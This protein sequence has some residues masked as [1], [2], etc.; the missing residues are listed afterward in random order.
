M[1]LPEIYIINLESSVARRARI[2]QS[3][4]RNLS[5]QIFPAI[6][7]Q[8]IGETYS[9]GEHRFAKT[10]LLTHNE[11]ACKMSHLSLLHQVVT[12]GLSGAVILED[13]VLI[14]EGFDVALANLVEQV[15]PD[16][17]IVYLSCNSN[18]HANV[19]WP[20]LGNINLVFNHLHGLDRSPE[21]PLL[22]RLH[23]AWGS[24]AYLVSQTGAKK[25]IQYVSE[26]VSNEF[27]YPTGLGPIHRYRFPTEAIDLMLVSNLNRL[28][29]YL[30]LPFLASPNLD[31]SDS[32]IGVERGY[33]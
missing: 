10:D 13:D 8:S 2:I 3:M 31:P 33:S 21:N 30:T 17:D 4:P 29:A 16:F 24:P 23:R 28:N 27:D 1:A 32:A 20:G 25:I 12:S 14:L 5:W 11:F 6:S 15:P 18:M 22:F 19:D 7:G 26:P 9:I